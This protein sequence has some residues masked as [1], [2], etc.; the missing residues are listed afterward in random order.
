M[1]PD[2]SKGHGCLCMCVS[3]GTHMWIQGG[4]GLDGRKGRC[5]PSPD[6]SGHFSEWACP[7]L[8]FLPMAPKEVPM[9]Q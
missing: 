7:T 6:Q 8:L 1:A 4:R 5:C 3:G 2:E 9:P